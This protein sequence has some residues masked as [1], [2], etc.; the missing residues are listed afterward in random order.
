MAAGLGI[1]LD[2][3]TQGAITSTMALPMAA[4]S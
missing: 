4:T 2:G 3:L 1:D